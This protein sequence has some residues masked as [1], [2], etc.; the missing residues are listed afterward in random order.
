MLYR[1]HVG[2]TYDIEVDDE[3]DVRDAA[4]LLAELDY[5]KAFG[6]DAWTSF[7]VIDRR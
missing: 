1:V 2:V 6:E 4:L 7:D 5:G 3:D